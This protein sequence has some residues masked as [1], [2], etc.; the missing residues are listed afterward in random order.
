MAELLGGSAE[1]NAAIT[2]GILAGA[3]H[4]P[5]RDAVLLNAAFALATECGD[6]PAG[7]EEARQSID[8]GRALGVLEAFVAKTRGFAG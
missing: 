6:L 7:L 8:S 3:I 5:K 1:E 2:Q 4:G